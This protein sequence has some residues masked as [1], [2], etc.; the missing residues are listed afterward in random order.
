MFVSSDDDV[1]SATVAE[2][3]ER[4]GFAPVEL[5]KLNEG[6]DAR[7]GARAYV[8]SADLPEPYQ[9]RK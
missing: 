6:G 7:S 5:G 9:V 4:L 8:G 1:A 2:L 3:V